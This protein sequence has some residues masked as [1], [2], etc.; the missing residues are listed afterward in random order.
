MPGRGRP[1][2]KGRSGN[3]TGRPKLDQTITELARAHGPRAIEVLR[4]LM[5]DPKASASARAMAAERLLDRAYGKPAQFS[6]GHAQEFRKAVDMTD[7]ELAAIVAAGKG[8]VLELVANKDSASGQSLRAKPVQTVGANV[9]TDVARTTEPKDI[10][11]A[12]AK[13][14]G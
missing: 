3:P 6:T 9:G 12:D 4:E 8:K 11:D 5:D 2:E 13:L 7:D 10:K 14:G 1:F